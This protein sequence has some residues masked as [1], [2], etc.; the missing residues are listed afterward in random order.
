MFS[1]LGVLPAHTRDAPSLIV[2]LVGKIIV[3]S[4]D[5]WLTREKCQGVFKN[6]APLQKG[7]KA[8]SQTQLIGVLS[9]RAI[10]RK[11]RKF[12]AIQRHCF[13]LFCSDWS[14]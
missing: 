3:G 2:W 14:S 7:L 8:S 1:V 9:V 5:K 12:S 10:I 11:S 4:E 13:L 6:T